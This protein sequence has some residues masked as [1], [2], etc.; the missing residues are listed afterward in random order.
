ML[1]CV[2]RQIF[3]YCCL[4]DQ[5][6]KSACCNAWFFY[7]WRPAILYCQPFKES[8]CMSS[9]STLYTQESGSNASY[10]V[11]IDVPCA[12]QYP[13]CAEQIRLLLSVAKACFQC[14]H[15]APLSMQRCLKECQPSK[16]PLFQSQDF[17]AAPMLQHCCKSP[18]A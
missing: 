3:V 10:Y 13:L 4:C 6:D 7:F 16:D 8:F 1:A 18:S 12:T 14:L 5:I 2:G 17:G 11:Q 9:V 15:S